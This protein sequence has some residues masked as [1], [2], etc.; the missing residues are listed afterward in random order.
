MEDFKEQWEPAMENLETAE[1]AFSG[2]DKLMD[3]PLGFDLAAGLWQQRGW[4][5]LEELRK[6]LSELKELR[7]LIRELGRGSGKVR[8]SG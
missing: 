1:K 3:G 2:L 7:D 8:A 4:L 6:K 5:E